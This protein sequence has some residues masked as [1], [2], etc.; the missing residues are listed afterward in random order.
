MN[1][2]TCAIGLKPNITAPFVL[3]DATSSSA[4]L[5]SFLQAGYINIY[6]N[7]LVGVDGNYVTLNGA[8]WFGFETQVRFSLAFLLRLQNV[9]LQR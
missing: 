1:G 4:N 5:S 6:G 3:P 2:E 7:R 8:N 9:Y